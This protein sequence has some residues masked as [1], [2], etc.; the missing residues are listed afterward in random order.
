MAMIPTGLPVAGKHLII[1][2]HPVDINKAPQG[3]IVLEVLYTSFDPYLRDK[4]IKSNTSNFAEGDLIISHLAIT[5]YI[6]IKKD[7]IPKRLNYKKES[8]KDA[9]PRLTP[10]GI[11]IYFKNIGGEHLEVALANM[12]VNGRIPVCGMI[13]EYNTPANQYKG[14]QGLIN[15]ISK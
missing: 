15:L 10:N 4:V 12:N 1:E 3:G 7:I 11:N 2:D 8:P 14:V 9:I 13:S 5:K 6:R